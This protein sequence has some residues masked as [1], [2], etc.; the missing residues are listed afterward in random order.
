MKSAVI[1]LFTKENR[2]LLLW[3]IVVLLAVI[4]IAVMIF[5][6]VECF[7]MSLTGIKT[8]PE[9]IKLI[10]WGI[11]GLI[12]ILGVMALFQRAAALDK[13]NEMTEESHIQERFNKATEH[14]GHA[15]MSV[16]IAAFNAFCHLVE[17]KPD[18]RKTIFD[19]LCAHLRQTT[20]ENYQKK[21]QDSETQKPTEI[22]PTEEVQSL[23]DVLFKDSSIF[24]GMIANLS[25]ANLRGA[26][27][28]KADLR[29]ANLQ[30]T[31]LLNARLQGANLLNAK[32]QKAN[33]Q[34]AKLQKA[35]LQN[36]KLQKANLQKANLQGANL[37]E[38]NLWGATIGEDT[39]VPDD[40]KD[41]VK[42]HKDGKA[43]AVLVNTEGEFLNII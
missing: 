3:G 33:L 17:I 18:W 34:K 12:A 11:S 2:K 8:K 4:L 22:K 30:N 14:L 36:A 16:R 10:G 38:A 43:D 15:S 24:N 1:A 28:R 13:Q 9:L 19:I 35:N 25:R 41:M 39:K 20:N 29:K 37:H 27:L 31:N 23:L 32:L 40:W 7:F 6:S 42:K 21:E 5:S 26:D